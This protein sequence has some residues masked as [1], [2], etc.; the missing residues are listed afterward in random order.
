MIVSNISKA[1]NSFEI[2]P[3]QIP[4]GRHWKSTLIT[5]IFKS[6]ACILHTSFP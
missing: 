2:L 3:Y 6:S 5:H 4:I 1:Q